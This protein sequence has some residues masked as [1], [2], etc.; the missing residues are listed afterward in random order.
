MSWQ[1][2]VATSS[3]NVARTFLLSFLG[4]SG[5]PNIFNEVGWGVRTFSTPAPHQ[6]IIFSYYFGGN[7]PDIFAQFPNQP[8]HPYSGVLAYPRFLSIVYHYC[9]DITNPAVI[10]HQ[11]FCCCRNIT[12]VIGHRKTCC[13]VVSMPLV[14]RKFAASPW[15]V[16]C[17]RKIFHKPLGCHQ[18]W[19]NLP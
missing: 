5:P 13:C 18:S 19:K 1:T 4:L 16:I 10:G 3:E 8:P 15:G 6:Q 11:K 2:R 12:F 7:C 14:I 17:H 9:T